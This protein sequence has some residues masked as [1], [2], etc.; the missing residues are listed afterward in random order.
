MEDIQERW[1]SEETVSSECVQ[2][3]NEAHCEKV[4]K[5]L[6]KVKEISNASISNQQKE[7]AIIESIV[8]LLYQT[9]LDARKGMYRGQCTEDS[10]GECK[11]KQQG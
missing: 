5:W 7:H 11:E 1:G 3:F 6:T 9:I 8:V 2:R 10:K 4:K